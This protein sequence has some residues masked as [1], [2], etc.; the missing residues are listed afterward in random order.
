MVTLFQTSQVPH[1]V[2]PPPGHSAG[3]G[4][5]FGPGLPMHGKL[6][7][8]PQ[9]QRGRGAHINPA[10]RFEPTVV[11]LFDDGW[12]SLAELPPLKTELFTETPKTIITRNDSPDIS[13][14]RSI[15]PYRGCEHGCVYCY[16][17]PAHSY[18]GLS[19]GRDFESKIFIKPNAAALLREEL[20]ATNYVPRTIALGANTDC[21]QPTERKLRTTRAVIEVLAEFK[22]PFGI[23]TKSALVTRDIDLMASLAELNLVKVA[24]SITTLDPKLAR[25]MEPRASTPSKRLAALEQ[26]AKA[27]IPTVVMMGPVIPGLNDMEIENILKAARNAGAREAGYTMLRLPHEVKDIFKDWLSEEHPDRAAKVMSLVRSVRH[28][29]EN[30]ANF[31][32]RQVGSG[33]YAWQVGRRF[34]L[35]CQR[36]G[37]NLNRLKLSTDHFRRPVLAGEQLTLI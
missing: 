26:L 8:L 25:S 14:D 32:E 17:R 16:A 23:V 34:Q 22:H 36:L 15:N 33:P 18:M 6:K 19:P 20:T 30:N 9:F 10:G 28:G 29:R 24:V 21:Y 5:G 2:P 35:A 11:E 31:G 27:G 3:R 4:P 37:L 12:D 1:P 7:S 13:F